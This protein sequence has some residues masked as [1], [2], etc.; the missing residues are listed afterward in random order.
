MDII[1]LFREVAYKNWGDEKI[2]DELTVAAIRGLELEYTREALQIFLNRN[3][4]ICSRGFRPP[5]CG[6]PYDGQAKHY[7]LITCKTITCKSYGREFRE[8][9]GHTCS[10]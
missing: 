10:E 7:N 4:M 1:Y 9:V 5:G 3:K 8:C 6:Q 2:A